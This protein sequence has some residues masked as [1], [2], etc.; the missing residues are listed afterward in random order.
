MRDLHHSVYTISQAGIF[1]GTKRQRASVNP[2]EVFWI[3][4]TTIGEY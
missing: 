3:W 1:L 4:N 2:Q